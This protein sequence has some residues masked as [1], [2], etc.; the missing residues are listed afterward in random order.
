[1]AVAQFIGRSR[2]EQALRRGAPEFLTER[3]LQYGAVPDPHHPALNRLHE[4]GKGVGTLVFLRTPD[5][6]G[7]PLV[8]EEVM[9]S[10]L[11]AFEF[12][13]NHHLHGLLG[14][15]HGIRVDLLHDGFRE[16]L[17]LREQERHAGVRL[18][19]DHPLPRLLR[20]AQLAQP[21]ARHGIRVGSAA[22]VV[23]EPA[24]EAELLEFARLRFVGV[25]VFRGTPVP[26]SQ[27]TAGYVGLHDDLV[28]EVARRQVSRH[29]LLV[30]GE[31]ADRRERLRQL[32]CHL[33]VRDAHHHGV[34]MRPRHAE[35]EQRLAAVEA[36][37]ADDLRHAILAA[38]DIPVMAGHPAV[39][40]AGLEQGRII[41]EEVGEDLV[42][43]RHREGEVR[44][45]G[46]GQAVA[47]PDDS[48]ERFL[49]GRQVDE[50][51]GDE[52][53][54]GLEALPDDFGRDGIQR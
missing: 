4:E 47:L 34:I 26:R 21:T 33:L 38:V 35:A 2:A 46:A 16:R 30:V 43:R 9:Q 15:F 49:L 13:K 36:A 17:A 24:R 20:L 29:F 52:T 19:H 14:V 54:V 7:Q 18:R 12:R 23:V 41:A 53:S 25:A 10:L 3:R 22:E 28:E 31:L 42:D 1:M 40:V 45:L 48:A 8:V 51:L 39:A 27:L 32:G 50:D 5:G 37:P 6:D 11:P 44:L